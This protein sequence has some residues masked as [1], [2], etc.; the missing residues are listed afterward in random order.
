MIGRQASAVGG[1]V[2]IIICPMVKCLFCGSQ[3]TQALV[4]QMG[5]GRYL[6]E[7]N[8]LDTALLTATLRSLFASTASASRSASLA[9]S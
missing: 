9:I 6:R 3:G 4:Q 8:L 7:Q 1:M 2:C 5:L